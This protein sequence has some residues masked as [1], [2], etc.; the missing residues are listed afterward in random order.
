MRKGTLNV[1]RAEK[2][3]VLVKNKGEYFRVFNLTFHT[4]KKG[5][6]GIFVSFPYLKN[7]KGLISRVTFPAN[8]KT[9]KKISLLPEGKLVTSLVKYS[10]WEDGNTHFSQT[11]KSITTLRN[12]S[13]PLSNTAD[14]LFTV[15]IQNLKGYTKRDKKK[16]N[17]REIDIDFDLRDKDMDALKFTGWW[18]EN[19]NINQNMETGGPIIQM[20]MGDG[21]YKIGFAV[22]TP[23][24]PKYSNFFLFLACE[25]HPALTKRKGIHLSFIGGFDQKAVANDLTKDMHFLSFIYPAFGYNRLLSKIQNIDFA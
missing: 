11:G 21:K 23:N 1:L 5:Q 19:I 4:N 17:N 9:A 15:M 14:H 12:L 8:K 2:F 20:K 25:E 3:N 7:S 22:S 6:F 16:S 24:N 18:Y 10:H 13:N